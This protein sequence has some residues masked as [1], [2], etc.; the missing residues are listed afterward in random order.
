MSFN[1]G[2]HYVEKC[3]EC[4]RIIGQCRCPALDKAVQWGVC[5]ECLA[6]RGK[7]DMFAYYGAMGGS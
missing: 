6:K 1:T 3:K 5:S 2:N 7:N 4:S